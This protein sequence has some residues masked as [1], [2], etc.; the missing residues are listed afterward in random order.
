MPCDSKKKGT[1]VKNW[2]DIGCKRWVWWGKHG[3]GGGH[4][5]GREAWG[6]MMV[7]HEGLMGMGTYAHA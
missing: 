5:M 7:G 6:G 1:K 4:G 3:G 2:V